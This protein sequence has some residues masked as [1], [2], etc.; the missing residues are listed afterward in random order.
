MKRFPADGD[1]LLVLR[2]M[3]RLVA[4]LRSGRRSLPALADTLRVSQRTILRD[5]AALR[6]AGVAVQRCDESGRRWIAG[7]PFCDEAVRS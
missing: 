2:R 4:I 7:C 3:L 1:R 6:A 5:L